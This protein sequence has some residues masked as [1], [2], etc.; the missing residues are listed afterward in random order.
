MSLE[1]DPFE[2]DDA[3]YVL[4]ALEPA[5]R[6]R[7]EEHLRTCAACQAR[8]DELAALPDALRGLTAA[9]FAAA[10]STGDVDSPADG[11]RA[12]DPVGADAGP[13]PTLILPRLVAQVSRE[14]RRR[15]WLVSGLGAAVAACVL[16]LVVAV[17]PTGNTAQPTPRAFSAVATTGIQARA[18]LVSRS[19]GTEVDLH[20]QYAAGVSVPDS[21]WDYELY[22]VT[23]TG[24]HYLG[25]WTLHEDGD[26]T[27]TTGTAIAT[28][29]ITA[30]EIRTP[31][32]QTLLRLT[33]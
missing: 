32:E 5:D 30:L 2:H 31:D 12:D 26:I 23:A 10:G 28:A 4:G 22:A 1:L 14:R 9:D 25:D 13:V 17:W 33:I 8:V 21:G 3:A 24:G 16:A 15:R 20:C 27:Y 29:D 11:H 6:A 18:A 7:F 19:W